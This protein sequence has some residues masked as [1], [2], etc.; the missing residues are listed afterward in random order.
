MN[1]KMKYLQLP[2]GTDALVEDSKIV[3]ELVNMGKLQLLGGR[4]IEQAYYTIYSAIANPNAL[5]AVPME[6]HEYHGFTIVG[7][8]E[9]GYEIK[10]D[11]FRGDSFSTVA[12]AE[13]AIDEYEFKEE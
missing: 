7:T 9:L 4:K 3:Q 13:E 2:N 6:V 1:Y 10:Y 5:Y 8:E 11:P 12:A